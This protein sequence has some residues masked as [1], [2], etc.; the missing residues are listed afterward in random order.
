MNLLVEK[1]VA[2]R[3]TELFKDI[4]YDRFGGLI[5]PFDDFVSV[6]KVRKVV[7]DNNFEI[8]L[9]EQR[10]LITSDDIFKS[11]DERAK[12]NRKAIIDIE[13]AR[14]RHGDLK[15]SKIENYTSSDYDL[16][17]KILEARKL[18]KKKYAEVH[19][20]SKVK[21]QSNG[22]TALSIYSKAFEEGGIYFLDEPEN[23][24]SPIFQIELIKLVQDSAK[25][26][27]CQFFICT[28]S[29]FILSLQDAI[30]YNLD[31]EPVIPQKWTEL[32]NV[33]IYYDFFESHKKEFE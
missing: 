4:F 26:F 13:N 29:P 1:I 33:Q 15:Y 6:I 17:V 24:L 12:H 5:H 21:M 27:G 3:K 32:E 19:A 7:D 11:I 25:Y 8:I 30:V 10:K 9:P 28:H 31:I 18:S 14:E 20:P 16:L 23:C 22:E 2:Q